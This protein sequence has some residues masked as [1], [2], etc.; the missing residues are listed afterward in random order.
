MNPQTPTGPNRK[1]IL[2]RL[3]LVFLVAACLIGAMA[4]LEYLSRYT[5]F[6]TSFSSGWSEQNFASVKKQEAVQVVLE[7][8]GP[9]L[10]ATVNFGPGG[11]LSKDIKLP[12][13]SEIQRYSSV[14]NGDIVL[15][16]T[17]C[18][19]RFSDSFRNVNITISNGQV[20]GKRDEIYHEW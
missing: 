4:T 10:Y 15:Q 16:Y 20:T 5:R 18:L 19:H 14:Q 3:S 17:E 6:N 8:L 9:P 13:A 7:K 11:G 2:K 1:T 12:S